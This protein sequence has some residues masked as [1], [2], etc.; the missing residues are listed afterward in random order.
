MGENDFV[1]TEVWFHR[2][3]KRENISFA[4]PH[5]EHGEADHEIARSWIHTE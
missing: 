2:W 1:A 5:E 3:K 4:N